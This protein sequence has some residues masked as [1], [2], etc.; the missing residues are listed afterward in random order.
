M[1]NEFNK[2]REKAT[3]KPRVLAESKDPFSMPTPSPRPVAPPQKIVKEPVKNPI[4][5][6]VEKPIEKTPELPKPEEKQPVSSQKRAKRPIK[7]WPILAA[8]AVVIAVTVTIFF[9]NQGSA[10]NGQNSTSSQSN[11]P[12]SASKKYPR[13]TATAIDI[14]IA[15]GPIELKEAG[16]YILS[17]ETT[18]PVV[19]NASGEVA[20]YLNGISVR[21]NGTSAISNLTDK[22][23]ILI[24][25]DGTTTN[26]Q[27][28]NMEINAIDS[29]G[30]L[31]IKGG[32]GILNVAGVN[33]A[34]GREFKKDA[35]VNDLKTTAERLNQ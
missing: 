26:L 31:T 30:D 21:S 11:E 27:T 14:A 10:N 2:I 17:G 35:I 4:E 8:V 22:P 18:S 28:D 24:L 20:I 7:L 1:D 19:V 9:I 32:S 12:V 5:K 3:P 33:V 13:E 6:P 16:H 15:T 29:A 25:E 34:E 23:L